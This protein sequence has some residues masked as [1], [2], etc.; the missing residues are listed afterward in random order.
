MEITETLKK[1]VWN[2]GVIVK[3]YDPQSYRKDAC[4]AWIAW[5]A[6]GDRHSPYGW[7][8]DHIY[9]EAKLQLKK[10]FQESIDDLINL[11]PLHCKNNASK[12]ADY[13]T[14][15]SSMKAV[16]NKNEEVAGVFDVNAEVQN[17]LKELYGF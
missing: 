17:K 4:G 5:S 8:I 11:R 13:P 2:K 1:E 14:Y 15:H 9:P 6:Y 16:G 12:G 10:V 3:D 7:E